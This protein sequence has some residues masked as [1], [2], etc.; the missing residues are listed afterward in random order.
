MV[1]DLRLGD[2]VRLRK[3]HPCGGFE[4]E[5]ERLGADIKIRCLEC[6]RLVMLTRSELAKRTKRAASVPARRPGFRSSLV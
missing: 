5:V 3:P 6:G 4:W 1:A 2:V